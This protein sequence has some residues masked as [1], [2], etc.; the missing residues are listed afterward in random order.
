MTEARPVVV[1]F[2]RHDSIYKTIPGLDVWDKARDARQWVGQGPVIAHPPCPQWSMLKAFAHDIPEEKEMALWA[3]GQ[4]R[5]HG[6]VLEHPAYSSLWR[7]PGIRA[8]KP[9]EFP[10]QYGGWSIQVDQW[11]WG[12]PAR[13]RTWLYIVGMHP[14]DLPE[15]PRRKGSPEYVVSRTSGKFKKPEIS[16]KRREETPPAFAHWLIEVARRCHV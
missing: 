9:R 4:V 10:D 16:H 2:A 15:R 1:L 12:H 13:K 7:H 6:G 8:P 5:K 3:M 11:H 14:N